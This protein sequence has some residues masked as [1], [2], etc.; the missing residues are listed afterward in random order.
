VVAEVTAPDDKT[1]VFKLKQPFAPFEAAIGAPI[2]W[3]MP[4][5]VIEANGDVSK[6]QH[7]IGSGPFIFDQFESGVRVTGKRN[8]DYYHPN[9]SNVDMISPIIPDTA[10][11]LAAVRSG[12]LD[13]YSPPSNE[14]ANL[15]KSNPE[16]K[17]YEF[18]QLNIP[19]MFWRVDAPPFNDARV[20]QAFSMMFN[21]DD[22]IKIIHN[23]RGEYNNVVPWALSEAW[24]NPRGADAGPGSKVVKHDPAEAKKLLDAA[25]WDWKKPVTMLGT[26]GY[27]QVFTQA[28][29]LVHQHLKQAGVNVELKMQEYNVYIS[30][31]FAGKFDPGTVVFGLETPFTEPH[32][33]LFNM[34]HPKGTRNH[35]GVND[36]KLNEMIEQQMRTVDKAKRKQ[37]IFDIQKYALEQAY[38][39]PGTAGVVMTAVQ[40]WIKNFFPISDYGHFAEVLSKVWVDK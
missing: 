26:P 9:E 32:D 40:P 35:A 13:I 19:F 28:I 29:E 37:L 22:Y 39:P 2:F 4:R 38:Y 17:W 12:Q 15:A 1:A 21:R 5:E 20:R 31:T 11:Q 23:G 27:G 30:T 10:T 25:G 3:I 16:L 14:I 7:V 24:L 6:P 18:P 33:Y 8:P 34:Y 36:A